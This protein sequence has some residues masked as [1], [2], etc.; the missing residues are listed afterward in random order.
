MIQQI[1]GKIITRFP[2]AQRIP[3]KTIQAVRKGFA[4]MESESQLIIEEKKREV[5]ESGGVGGGKD[6]MTL[7]RECLAALVVGES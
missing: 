3:N 6:L 5:A 4:T 1:L 7:L 2:I